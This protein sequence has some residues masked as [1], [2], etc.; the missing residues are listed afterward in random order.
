M[1]LDLHIQ[2]LISEKNG[3][4]M[5]N[6]LQFSLLSDEIFKSTQSRLS[7][8]TLKRLYGMLPEVNTTSTTLD[9]IAKYLG[10]SSWKRLIAAGMD[11]HSSFNNDFLCVLPKEMEAGQCLT[12]AYEPDRIMKLKITQDYWCEVLSCTGG[13]ICVGD[14]LDIPSLCIHAPLIVMEVVREG[15]S[16][17]SYIGGKEGGV[18]EIIL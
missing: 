16:L 5:T 6:S 10:Y 4:E 14:L 7:V 2:K 17:G 18:T 9:I 13:K 15:Q 1:V 11:I 3:F 8:N 12:I